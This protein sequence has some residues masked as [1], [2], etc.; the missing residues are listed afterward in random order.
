MV[1]LITCFLLNPR[2]ASPFLFVK[3]SSRGLDEVGWT[4]KFFSVKGL[5]EAH[6]TSSRTLGP[7][8]GQVNV[9]IVVRFAIPAFCVVGRRSQSVSRATAGRNAVLVSRE[10]LVWACFEGAESGL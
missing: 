6:S 4:G 1:F 7:F 5:N 2:I 9:S 10:R 8:C 3:P